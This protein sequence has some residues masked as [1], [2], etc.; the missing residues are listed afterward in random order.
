M[1]TKSHKLTDA[2]REMF[3]A[4]LHALLTAGLDFSAA[5]RLLIEGEGDRRTKALLE[6]LYAAVV[7]HKGFTAAA[8]ALSVPKSKISK[9]VAALEEQLGVRLIERSTRKLA[10]TDIGQSFYERCEAVLSGVEAAEA[11]KRALAKDRPSLLAHLKLFPA[12]VDLDDEVFARNR[13]PSREI[14]L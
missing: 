3:Y 7:R 5:F 2:R 6:E 12:D 11:A 9:R 10:I 1:D 14:E 13:Q 4:E 8:N